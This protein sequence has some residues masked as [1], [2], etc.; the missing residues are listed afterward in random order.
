[1]RANFHTHTVFCDG[2]DSPS[3]MAA[4]AYELGFEALGFSGHSGGG[5]DDVGMDESA[6][7]AYRA[8]IA[9]LKSEYAGRMEI[10][11]GIEQDCTSGKVPPEYDYAIG[12][13]HYVLHDGEYLC[14]DRSVESTRENIAKYGGDAYAY[15]EDYFA[16]VGAVLEHT[17]AQIVGHFDLIRKFDEQDPVFDETRPRYRRAVTDALDRLCADGK[18]PIFEINTGAMAR[19]YR[20]APYPS[21]WILR[22]IRARGCSIMITTD[23]HDREKLNFGYSAAAGLARAAGFTEQVTIRGGAF[24]PAGL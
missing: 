11:L 5:A 20:S 24:V 21:E 12:S 3:E 10:Y 17:G 13:V 7:A 14:V 2:K 23:C 9:L 8:E 19:G 1:M 4:R 16:L 18:R 15:A 6:T 22:E